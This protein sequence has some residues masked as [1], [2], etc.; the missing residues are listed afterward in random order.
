MEYMDMQHRI[1]LSLISTAVL[2]A[3]TSGTAFANDV[4]P[5]DIRNQSAAAVDLATEAKQA[6]YDGSTSRLHSFLYIRDREQKN[7][8]TGEWSPN[9]EN[10]TLQLA[11]DYKSGYFK[12]TIG[13]DIWAN[14]NLQLGNTTGMSE[15]LYFDHECQNNPAYDGKGCEKSYA[16][17]SVAALKAKFGNE[18]VGLALRGGYTQINIGTIR[19]SWGL[20]PH[21]YRGLEA[22]AHF[23]NLI[24][25]YAIADQFKND[26]RKEFLPMTTKWHQ[27]QLKGADTTNTVIDHIQ[28]LGAIY[29]FDQGQIDVGY[30]VGKDYRQNW[31]ALGKYNFDLGSAKV[32]LSAFYHGSILEKSALTTNVVSN[33]EE[34]QSYLGLGANIK[35]GGFTWIAGVSSTDTGGQELS[36]N[37]RLTPWANSDNRNFQQTTSG[38]DD[39]NADGTKAVKLAVNYNFASWDL[40]ELTAGI[41]GNYGTNVRSSLTKKEYDGSMYS[42]DWNIGYKFMDGALEGLNI[43]TFR[44]KFRGDDIVHKADRNDTKVLI[45]Y[46]VKLK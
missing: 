33:K 5:N 40:P 39:Y 44:S 1:N 35:H 21:A 6:F 34:A 7:M 17:L 11:W 25:G 41:G 14:T 30:G 22:K 9:I 4:D 12:D 8:T 18:D 27:N 28:T 31:Q 15:I 23:G 3:L 10:Q 20:N 2:A 32:G 38:L 19:S 13:L 24:V 45:S 29:K 46:S 26:W 43:R 16:A 42:F 37:F 36:Y